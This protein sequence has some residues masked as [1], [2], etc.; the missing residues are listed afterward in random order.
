MHMTRKEWKKMNKK[1]LVLSRKNYTSAVIVGAVTVGLVAGV[2]V[3]HS[4][5][6]PKAAQN[7][8]EVASNYNEIP[9]TVKDTFVGQENTIEKQGSFRTNELTEVISKGSGVLSKIEQAK[10]ED[11]ERK[12]ALNLPSSNSVAF[13]KQ[14]MPE[15]HLVVNSEKVSFATNFSGGATSVQPDSTL[16]LN[17]VSS[18]LN[19]SEQE[20]VATKTPKRE[21][22]LLNINSNYIA[23]E[24]TNEVK[25]MEGEKD[26]ETSK[27]MTNKL[28]SLG[29]VAV[30]VNEDILETAGTFTGRF[31]DNT[32]ILDMDGDEDS[33]YTNE[34]DIKDELKKYNVGS[35]LNVRYSKDTNNYNRINDVFLIQNGAT[36]NSREFEALYMGKHQNAVSLKEANSQPKDYEMSNYFAKE[37]KNFLPGSQV[38]VVGANDDKGFKVENIDVLEDP[39]PKTILPIAKPAA[40]TKKEVKP[41]VKKAEVQASKLDVVEDNKEEVQP[42]ADPKQEEAVQN[43][44]DTKSDIANTVEQQPKSNVNSAVEPTKVTPVSTNEE[45]PVELKETPDQTV[46][47]VEVNEE[48][49][50]TDSPEAATT[51]NSVV[52]VGEETLN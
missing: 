45:A 9:E 3:T 37:N 38:W 43:T 33:F 29:K 34:S 7:E 13:S 2:A 39:K 31:G 49:V 23:N 16:L 14:I 24:A 6:Q 19:N 4:K 41:S 28:N 44:V 22:E 18:S 51:D 20:E 12:N 5:I 47:A 46:N 30:A 36:N 1:K 27:V 15:K 48:K 32:I 25:T 50:T 40:T 10:K 8:I 52:E 42:T 11:A 17:N 35:Y 26:L 21:E